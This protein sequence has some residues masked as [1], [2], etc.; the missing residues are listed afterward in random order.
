V[1]KI[2]ITNDG[3]K[4]PPVHFD[5]RKKTQ[6]HFCGVS[7]PNTQSE[8]NHEEILDNWDTC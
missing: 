5:L 6:H 7:A 4:Q 3:T 1:A 2:D 8:S